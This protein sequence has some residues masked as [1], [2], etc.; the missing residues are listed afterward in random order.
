VTFLFHRAYRTNIWGGG[1]P[2]LKYKEKICVKI[3][4]TRWL[5]HFSMHI[6][7]PQFESTNFSG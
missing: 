3:F 5:P 2:L 1:M 7:A 4:S 6:K